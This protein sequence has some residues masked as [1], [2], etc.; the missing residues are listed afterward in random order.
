LCPRWSAQLAEKCRGGTFMLPGPRRHLP[1]KLVSRR[2]M[3]C[4]R[5]CSLHSL[6]GGASSNLFY[7]AIAPPNRSDVSCGFLRSAWRKVWRLLS[8]ILD[9]A[10]TRLR[11]MVRPLGFVPCCLFLVTV[12][13]TCF[14]F[15]LCF[16]FF[17]FELGTS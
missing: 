13:R 1:N 4:P 8:V 5:S 3:P 9:A 15:F 7:I 2:R 16:F 17:V 10:S 11:S 6:L 14:I 12:Y